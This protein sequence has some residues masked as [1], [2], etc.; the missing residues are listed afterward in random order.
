MSETTRALV[1]ED[2]AHSLVAIASILRALRIDYKRNTSG[3]RVI[4]QA[5]ATNPDF[6][7]L[8]MDLPDGD[9]FVIYDAIR[10]CPRLK[11]VPVIAIGENDVLTRLMPRVENSQFAGVMTKPL[12]QKNLDSLLHALLH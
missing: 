8:D 5:L 6:I 3:A 9:P 12:V 10:T 2:D 7:L 11:N 1:V 4:E